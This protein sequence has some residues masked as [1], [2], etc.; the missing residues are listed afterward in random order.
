M[1]SGS[2]PTPL[3]ARTGEFTPPG[4]R[5]LARAS[6][7]R[8]CSVFKDMAGRDLAP[9]PATVKPLEASRSV[10]DGA[11]LRVTA[12]PHRCLVVRIHR[13]A[14]L[15]AALGALQGIL[16]RVR[17]VVPRQRGGIGLHGGLVVAQLGEAVALLEQR[18]G[19]LLGAVVLALDRVVRGDRV[20]VPA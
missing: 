4:K 20:L 6:S 7:R 14:A 12:V 10:L 17:G 11:A 18:L 13:A 5:A 9:L 8:D 3:N 2:P 19:A 1:K 15:Q 16:D